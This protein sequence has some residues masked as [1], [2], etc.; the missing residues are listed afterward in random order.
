MAEKVVAIVGARLN[1]SRLPK[2]HL[3]PL[4]G[5]PLISHIFERLDNVKGISQ[6]VL[7]TT[8][9]GYNL[10]IRDWAKEEGRDCFA[11]SG[12]VN[13]LVGRVDAVTQAYKADIILYVC[14]DCP[15][16]EPE[17]IS[18]MLE[19]V[20]TDDE[21]DIVQLLSGDSGF[22]NIH[23]GFDIYRKRFW[24]EMVAVAHEPFEREHIGAVYHHLKKVEPRKIAKLKEP[25][26]FS[27]LEHRVSVDTPS[28]YRFMREVYERWSRNSDGHKIVDLTWVIEELGRDKELASINVDVRQKKIR[29]TSVAITILTEVGQEV[30]L[31]H[32]MRSLAAAGALQDYL[33]A[34]VEI[35]IRGEPLDLDELAL[36]PH[37][38]VDDFTGE[39]LEQKIKETEVFI[40]DLKKMPDDVVEHFK[41]SESSC[42]TIGIDFD[43]QFDDFFDLVWIPSFYVDPARISRYAAKICYGWDS[44]L[45]RRVGASQ[46]IVADVQ[47]LL[48]LTGGSDTAELGSY[49]PERLLS[50]LGSDIQHTWLKGAYASAPEV[51]EKEKRIDVVEAP[52]DVLKLITEHDAIFSV[53]GVS[54]FEAIYAGKP[55]YTFDAVGA[56]LPE[57]WEA[58]K[59]HLPDFVFD[60]AEE[61]LAA[62]ATKKSNSIEALKSVTNEIRKG[63]QR[64]ASEIQNRFLS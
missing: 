48:V 62:I 11:F 8:S 50:Q 32:L 45:L 34:K 46:S 56:A 54:F 55:A 42:K 35:I 19:A 36:V 51:P 60:S 30:G 58:L 5:R 17:T 49:L 25:E 31:G 21:V 6:S 16:I 14:G 27:S 38:W 28:D 24:D 29:D 57:E 63:A 4:A 23:E 13:D 7:A 3:L 41:Q 22:K 43:A 10:P 2:K 20:I 37:V 61:A 47:S 15:L 39:F 52:A 12:D 44:Y 59:E 64:F 53:Y 9:D 40:F 33:S 26:V 18:R 1:S